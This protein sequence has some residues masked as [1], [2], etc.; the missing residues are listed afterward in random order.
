MKKILF[1]LFACLMAMSAAAQQASKI[2]RVYKGNEVVYEERAD[3]LDSVVLVDDVM[4]EST[5]KFKFSVSP[6]RQV[7]FSKGNLQYQPSTNTWRFAENQYDVIGA[8]NS[9]ISPSYSGWIDLFGWGTGG[10]PTFSSTAYR[11]YSTF[12]E[13]G[14]C[15]ISN[16]GNATFVW[17]TLSLE[18]W[19]YLIYLR[20][21]A[22]QKIGFAEIEGG[23]QGIVLLPD[24][25]TAP[26]IYPTFTPNTSDIVNFYEP[27][28]WPILENSG[29][30]FLPA[31]SIR[32]GN[33]ADNNRRDGYYWAK[34]SWRDAFAFC[35]CFRSTTLWPEGFYYQLRHY[36]RAVRLVRT[37]W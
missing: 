34:E 28:Q 16:G 36:G 2:V 19:Y 7:Y 35:F 13:W 22:K 26:D 11:D 17:R 12:T 24:E 14:S 37:A 18:E 6:T 21:D 10:N 31:T 27:R 9:N 29:A 8:G 5:H 32:N 33:T 25:W 1:M 23:L 30:I 15:P 20:P 3:E 4:Y